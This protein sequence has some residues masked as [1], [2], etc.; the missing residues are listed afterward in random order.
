[1]FRQ[2]ALLG[3]FAAISLAFPLVYEMNPGAIESWIDAQ[4][5]ADR[6]TAVEPATRIAAA[7]PEPSPKAQ[8]LVGRKVQVRANEGGHFV[9][10]FRLN[11]RRIDAMIDTG[12]TTV[13]LNRSLARRIGI[14]LSPADFKYEVRTA[15]GIVKGAAATIDRVQVGRITL[16]RIDA[17]VLDDRA[18][19]G[20]LVGM[21]FL[22]QLSRF[23]VQ[24][25]IL[26]MQQ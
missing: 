15:N 25:G 24:G 6:A 7:T 18:L 5:P 21:S 26:T 10:E 20:V 8:P 11:G 22:N 14:S 3:M 17:L 16:E 19:D 9:A 13:A 12:A 4:E 2:L 23:Q 1:M